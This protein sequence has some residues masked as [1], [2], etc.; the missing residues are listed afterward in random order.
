M[1]RS[2]PPM[3]DDPTSVLACLRSDF[4]RFAAGA[5]N[6]EMEHVLPPATELDLQREE[7]LLGVT[8][9]E[10]YKRLLRCTRGFW[11]LG[12]VIQLGSQHPF[13]HQF[14]SLSELT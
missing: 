3:E 5:R 1:R 10:T 6:A 11:L 4:P 9:P 8:L 2:P 14:P 13:F 7:Q 12:G